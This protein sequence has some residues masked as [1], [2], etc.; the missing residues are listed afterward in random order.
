MG[1]ELMR[2]GASLLLGVLAI[3]CS[4]PRTR[5]TLATCEGDVLF[6]A[7]NATTGLSAAQCGGTCVCGGEAWTPP[8]YG[9]D[10]VAALLALQIDAPL[11]ELAGD[12]YA[13]ELPAL[14]PGDPSMC[15]VL[16]DGDRY[17]LASYDTYADAIDDGAHVTHTGAC[18]LCSTLQDLAVYMREP[19]LTAPVRQCGLDFLMGPMEDH[20]ACLE[21]LGFTRP[22][23]QIWYWNTQNTKFA[24]AQECFAALEDPYHL[25]DGSLNACLQCDEEHSGNTFK[26][27][28]GRTRRNTGLPNALCRPCTEVRPI[29]HDWVR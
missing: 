26:T 28:A 18:G 7:P 12:P 6:G 4:E 9:E 23:A 17:T 10:D 15:G 16:T 20:V 25:P 19:D 29:A 11:P 3:A 27:I 14:D 5:E 8:V 13:E 21:A 24:C 22:C 2:Y 1:D